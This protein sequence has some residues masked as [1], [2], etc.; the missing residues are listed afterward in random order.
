MHTM[1]AA[2][3]MVC[4]A[5]GAL[6]LAA[7]Q[8]NPAEKPKAEP[9]S[10]KA[11]LTGKVVNAVSGDPLKKVKLML[12]GSATGGSPISTETDDKG[13]FFFGD[14]K[15]GRYMLLAQRNGFAPQMYGAR[16]NSMSGTLLVLSAGQQM[17]DLEF[18]IFPNSVIAGKVLDV[19][20]EPLQNVTVMA[21]SPVYTRGKRQLMPM[22]APAQTNDMGEYR[23]SNL[24]AGKYVI[25]AA[26]LMGGAMESAGSSNKPPSDSPEPSY[27]TTYYPSVADPAAVTAVEVGVGSEVNGVEIH[28]AQVDGYRV[29]GKLD[30]SQGKPLMV[31]L[32]RKGAGITGLLTRKMGMVQPDGTFEIRGA[33]PGSYILTATSDGISTT[34]VALPVEVKD[35][36]VKGL[37]MPSASTGELTGR[38]AV[39]NADAAHPAKLKGIEVH[40]QP[41]DT[42]AI[43]PPKGTVGE[44]GKFSIK[45]LAAD[46]YILTVT[47]GPEG[48]YVKSARYGQQEMPDEGL[49]LTNGTASALEITLSPDGAVVSGSVKGADDKPSQGVTVVLIPNSHRH[50]WYHATTTDQG[51]AYEFKGVAPGDYK[52]LAWEDIEP[53]A[54]EDPEFSG[55]YE[56]KA[57]DLSLKEKDHK[58]VELKSIPSEKQR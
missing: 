2:R 54:Y 12:T 47:G 41:V 13:G 42:F 52:L 38:V 51:G 49:N 17:K 23:I 34:G 20:G 5:A 14:L 22:S 58:T 1:K 8:A 21:L 37:V 28:M 15:P 40:L 55:K 7:F 25:A 26:N 11:S 57:E 43:M 31:L 46:H 3:L 33:A 36:H 4:F 27:T 48:S 10:G 50:D 18:R 39:A 56:G 6:T 9:D 44:D 35:Q 45:N 30:I 24:K 53:G 19:D 32:T 29:Q 16:G